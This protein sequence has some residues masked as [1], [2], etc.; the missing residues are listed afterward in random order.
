MSQVPTEFEKSSAES[1]SERSWVSRHNVSAAIWS[2]VFP[3]CTSA[4]SVRLGWT[5]ESHT[6]LAR[7]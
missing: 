4:P 3:P 7:A 6:A 5:P 2:M 1:S